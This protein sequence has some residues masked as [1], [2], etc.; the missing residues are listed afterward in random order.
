MH[1]TEEKGKTKL[2]LSVSKTEDF[3]LW[4]QEVCMGASFCPLFLYSLRVNAMS[5][6]GGW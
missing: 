6:V 3:S 2:A 4:Y 1:V 5:F